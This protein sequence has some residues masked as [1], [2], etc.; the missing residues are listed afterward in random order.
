MK[1]LSVSKTESDKI[2]THLKVKKAEKRPV[3]K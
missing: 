3:C 2:K 1:N